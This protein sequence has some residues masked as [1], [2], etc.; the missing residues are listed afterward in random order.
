VIGVVNRIDLLVR[1]LERLDAWALRLG[2][3]ALY[4]AW[5]ARLVMI[6]RRVSITSVSGTVEGIAESVDRQGGLLIREH[7]GGLRR[8]IAGDIALGQGS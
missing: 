8:M 7:T 6:G 1:L 5:R 2:S 4:E 3:E